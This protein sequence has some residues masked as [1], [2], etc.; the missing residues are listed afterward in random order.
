MKPG[1]VSIV[2]PVYNRAAMLREAVAS[3]LS[4]TWRPIE[5]IIV[6][7]GSS[8][9]TPSAANE[10]VAAHPE[11][12]RVL[13]QHN[14]GPGAARQAGADAAEGEFVQFLDSDD[15]LL[16]HK[17]S[18]Q[19]SGLREDLEAGIS[20]GKT[21]TCEN[22]VRAALPA[23]RSA[24]IHREIFPALLEGRIW[25]TS[26]PLYRRSALNL[27]GPWPRKRQMEDWEFDAK[28][29]AA[30][31]KLHYCDEFLAEYRIHGGERLAHA[32]M[33]ERRAMADRISAYSEILRYA[34]FAGVPDSRAEMRRYVRTLFAV[35]RAAGPL[36]FAAEANELL[37]LARGIATD[38]LSEALDLRA[39]NYLAKIL[40]WR[41]MGSLNRW[42]ERQ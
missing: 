29:G 24:Q 28:A 30:H 10:L 21:Y 41:V 22:G 6:D 2:I 40:G 38:N 34:R 31:V 16:P 7:D 1:L 5:I 19:I 37:A 36:G 27:I 42:L 17:F 13:S 15:L 12:I 3:V 39:Y 35:A 20:Y 8:D 18:R 4:Q 26:T 23:Q 9:E 25:E 14:V 32:W 33:T 11:V